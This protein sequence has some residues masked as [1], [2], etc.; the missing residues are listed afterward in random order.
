MELDKAQITGSM[1]SQNYSA[2]QRSLKKPEAQ[3]LTFTRRESRESFMMTLCFSFRGSAKTRSLDQ[4]QKETGLSIYLVATPP[5]LPPD[6]KRFTHDAHANKNAQSTDVLT[7][8]LSEIRD[9]TWSQQSSPNDSR[10]QHVKLLALLKPDSQSSFLQS[11]GT[12]CTNPFDL[13]LHKS[14]SMLSTLGANGRSHKQRGAF[15]TR[16]P[17]PMQPTNCWALTLAL[18]MLGS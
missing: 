16:R 6:S 7:L 15:V 3:T 13:V 12:S 17:T 4:T 9:E 5:P 1:Q 11:T 18:S 8:L 14:N 2:K 10:G